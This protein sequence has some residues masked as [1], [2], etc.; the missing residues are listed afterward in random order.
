MDGNLIYC[1]NHFSIYTRI[2][3]CCTPKTKPMLYVNYIFKHIRKFKKI[4][5][6]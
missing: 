6:L 3:S 4:Y 5:M 2:K 1:G